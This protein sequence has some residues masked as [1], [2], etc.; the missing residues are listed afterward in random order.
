MEWRVL[1]PSLLV[2]PFILFPAVFV[3][4]LNVNGLYA[5]AKEKKS[6]FLPLARTLRIIAALIPPAAIYGLAVWFAFGHFGWAVVLF[7]ALVMPV[8]LL[9][10]VLVWA[11]V[12]SG[13]YQVALDA[14]RRR[15]GPYRRRVTRIPAEVAVRKTA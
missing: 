13:L 8:M 10:P 11:A 1:L 4:Y 7:V 3:W 6:V 14:L 2:V 5:A 9:V 12:V 15:G